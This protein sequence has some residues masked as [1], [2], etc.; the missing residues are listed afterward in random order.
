MSFS[1]KEKVLCS[2]KSRLFPIKNLGKIP[3]CEQTA[4]SKPEVA[5]RLT[6][7]VA[8]EPTPIK[9][10]ESK[11]KLEKQFMHGII[12]DEKDINNEIL[13]SCLNIKKPLFLV[14]D[15]ISTKQNKN[16]KLVNNVNN[17]LTDLR[18]GINRKKILKN[19]NPKKVVDIV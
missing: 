19:E 11:L 7:K 9:H 10:Q 8:T 5:T 4:E 17:R 12:A 18:N 3:T 16:D 2:F 6:P 15:L 13:L 1:A 14:K